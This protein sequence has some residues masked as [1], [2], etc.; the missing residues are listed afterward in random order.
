MESDSLRS[1]DDW[2]LRTHIV[3]VVSSLVSPVAAV[4]SPWGIRRESV[5]ALALVAACLA[6]QAATGRLV[7]WTHPRPV[8]P[9]VK[10]VDSAAYVPPRPQSVNAP[11][12][13]ATSRAGRLS[14]TL[15]MPSPEKAVASAGDVPLAA[16]DPIERV[17]FA[18]RRGAPATPVVEP[19]A[20]TPVV[21]AAAAGRV[22]GGAIAALAATYVGYPYA[23]GGTSP[24]GFDCS[25]LVW[26][27]F[28]RV[29]I[30]LPRDLP[31]QLASGTPVARDDLQPGDV[32]FFV[33]TYQPGLSH[34]GIYLG[35]GRF[36]SAIDEATGVAISSL[37][38]PYWVSRYFAAARPR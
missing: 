20:S 29:G 1:P 6:Q 16:T 10:T 21:D 26:Y 32:V 27:V 37:S 30:Q 17:P 2:H 9:V 11:L 4:T 23:W 34:S 38:S 31:G 25:G 5:L 22:N 8:A 15:A 36:V 14:G 13:R 3:N 35:G 7:A 19:L 12:P 33:N 18:T 28:Q 24:A